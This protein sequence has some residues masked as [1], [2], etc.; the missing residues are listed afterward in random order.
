MS[1]YRDDRE[2]LRMRANALEEDLAAKQKEIDKL[3]A[4]GPPA[5]RLEKLSNDLADAQQEIAR[6]KQ[7]YGPKPAPQ[8]GRVAAGIA[9]AVVAVGGVVAL[10]SRKPSTPTYVAPPKISTATLDRDLMS[11]VTSVKPTI[12]DPPP[13]P[14]RVKR[15]MSSSWK[16]KVKRA[17]GSPYAPGTA[18]E[19]S[20]TV[21]EDG[22]LHAGGVAVKCGDG[23]LYSSSDR[24]DG[25]SSMSSGVEEDRVPGGFARALVYSDKGERTGKPQ[26]AID[27]R[28]R[29]ARVWDDGATKMEVELEVDTYDPPVASAF[30]PASVGR[31][32]RTS[33]G[34]RV[35][36]VEGR[37]DLAAGARCTVVTEPSTSECKI[38]VK[39]GV[40]ALY[41][42][43]YAPFVDGAV[44]D[45]APTSSGGD[46]R[47]RI[48]GR[49]V[50]LSDDGDPGW[51]VTI[52]RDR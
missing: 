2:A 34:G 26:I 48:E 1:N 19:I 4:D 52:E 28:G 7:V 30:N 39:C 17:K 47:L 3:R 21:I 20:A 5:E 45:D 44:V 36:T 41:D 46:P 16:A 6:L 15:T 42:G 38:T 33:G 27:T 8:T 50:D 51:K 23:T 14:E 35:K 29:A 32:E 49:A 13:K 22:A 12:P 37:T 18:C 10:A 43:G 25:T 31:C 11:I 24:F 9:V 40:I